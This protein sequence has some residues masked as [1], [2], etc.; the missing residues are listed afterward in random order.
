MMTQ[1][2]KMSSHILLLR[3]IIE[4]PR[5]QSTDKS[6]TWENMSLG[7]NILSKEYSP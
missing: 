2:T 1:R 4:S 6:D 3:I 5:M 7:S